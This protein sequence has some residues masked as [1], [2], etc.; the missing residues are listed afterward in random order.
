MAKRLFMMLVALMWTF[1]VSA[2]NRSVIQDA[3]GQANWR[4]DLQLLAE[5]MPQSHPKLFWRVKEKDFKAAIAKL[6][7]DIPYLT[8]EQIQIELIRIVA[9]IDGHTRIFPF[10]PAINIHLYPL[11]LYAFSDGIFVIQA[12]APYQNAVGKRLLR[13]GKLDIDAAYQRI[14]PLTSR[15]N[16]M[17][18]K[19]Q[20]PLYLIMSEALHALGVVDDVHQPGFV[21]VDG[22]GQETVLNPQPISSGA[23]RAWSNGGFFVGLP[24]QPEPLTLQHRYDENFWFTWLEDSK[25]L[26]IEYNQVTPS[27]ASGDSI[28]AFSRKIADFAKTKSIE[29]VVLD[30]RHNSGG[31]NTTYRP[32]LNLFSRNPTLN[33][34]GKLFTI[35]GRQ[36]FSAATNF[37]TEMER[38]THTVFVGEPTGGSPN[39]YGDTRPLTLPHSQIMVNI[40]SRYWQKSTPD[41]TRVWIEPDIPTPLSAVDFFNR[42]D[43]AMEAILAYTPNT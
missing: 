27:T 33:Q 3:A 15:D 37:A 4:D 42:R 24:Q 20:I 5:R 23:Y 32:F 38:N 19:L 17:T 11:R 41:D 1:T 40:S 35:I 31:D 16:E 22:S 28:S 18:V 34:P 10:Q 9:L 6:D 8:D 36:T 12:Q 14:A 26:Y 30:L 7:A 39:L 21:V 2:Q 25:T 43:P 13:L 29:K